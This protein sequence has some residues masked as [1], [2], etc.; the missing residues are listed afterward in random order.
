MSIL[1]GYFLLWFRFDN[2]LSMAHEDVREEKALKDKLH[3][4]RDE[5]LAEK[6][7]LEQSLQVYFDCLFTSCYSR[8]AEF[9]TSR[10]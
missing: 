9:I 3:R 6:Y 7:S 10:A 1:F 2:E 8:L 4:E 5:L